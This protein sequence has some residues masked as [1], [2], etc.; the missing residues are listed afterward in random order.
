MSAPLTTDLCSALL[1]GLA[2]RDGRTRAITACERRQCDYQTSAPIDELDVRFDDGE[3]LALI[4]KQASDPASINRGRDVKPRFLLDPLREIETYRRL[5]GDGVTGPPICYSTSVDRGHGRYWLFLERVNGAHLWQFGELAPWQAAA[6][7]LAR[8]HAR[9]SVSALPADGPGTALVHDRA[10]HRVW[11]E[12]AMRFT[13]GA[14][15]ASVP[16]ALQLA[17]LA[18]RYEQVLDGLALLPRTVLHGEFYASNVLIV[19]ARDGAPEPIRVCPL[20]WELTAVGPAL[21]DLAALVAGWEATAREA[22]VRAYFEEQ[23][24]T[25]W[26][27]ERRALLAGLDLCELELAIRMLGW[28]EDWTPPRE[29]RQDWLALALDAATRSKIAP[30][31]R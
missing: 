24:S 30:A 26:F 3:E 20:D 19:P 16:A 27:A 10:F 11:L 29:H 1:S 31:R 25:G 13:A 5:L 18:E 22:I 12:R 4:V 21:C 17:A 28:A 7:W 14:R 23:L 8:F 9:S 2:Q 6:R 15:A